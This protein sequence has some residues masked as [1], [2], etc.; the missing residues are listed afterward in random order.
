MD[1]WTSPGVQGYMG[2]T[3]HWIDRDW[4]L[5]AELIE[6]MVVQGSHTGEN[7]AKILVKSL[8]ELGITNKVSLTLF[9]DLVI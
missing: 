8:E 9:H 5:R 2:I 1:A 6:F 4:R 7:F 3:A